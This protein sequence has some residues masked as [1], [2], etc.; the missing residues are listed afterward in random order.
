MSFANDWI[1]QW[2]KKHDSFPTQ[3]QLGKY[4]APKCAK[5]KVGSF[6]HARPQNVGSFLVLNDQEETIFCHIFSGDVCMPLRAEEKA[7]TPSSAKRLD[8]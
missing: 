6:F 4:F 3:F 1:Q 2:S 7:L 5:I 8:M